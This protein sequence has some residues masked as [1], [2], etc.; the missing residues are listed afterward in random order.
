VRSATQ[1]GVAILLI[2]FIMVGGLCSSS[3][4]CSSSNSNSSFTLVFVSRDRRVEHPG[5]SRLEGLRLTFGS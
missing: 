3:S 1:S 5:I 2:L 4:A